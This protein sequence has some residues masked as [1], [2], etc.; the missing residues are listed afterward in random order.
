MKGWVVEFLAKIR[1]GIAARNHI[2]I[3][4]VAPA[5]AF[6]QG[7]AIKDRAEGTNK[8]VKIIARRDNETRSAKWS[9]VAT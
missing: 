3:L 5:P 7:L 4:R 6:D 2:I 8:R 1:I 9:L